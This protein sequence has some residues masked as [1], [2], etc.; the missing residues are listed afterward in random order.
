MAAPDLRHVAAAAAVAGT[1]IRYSFYAAGVFVFLTVGL[2][3]VWVWTRLPPAERDARGGPAF[4]LTSGDISRRPLVAHAAEQGGTWIETLQFGRLHDRDIDMTLMLVAP[5]ARHREIAPRH[6]A[7][8][9]ADLRPIAG[10]QRSAADPFYDLETR[11]GPVT[12][13]SFR[14]D[15]DGR[16][17]LCV[18]FLSRFDTPAFLYK[19]W[20]CEANGARPNFHTLACALDQLRMA[21]RLPSADAAAFLD[22]RMKRPA[23]C[24]AEPVSQTT[25]SG[26]RQPLR[27]LLR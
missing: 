14:I 22:E 5:A 24:S 1:A 9:I 3:A 19:G 20:Y 10:R 13:A 4:T 16:T 27:R 12:A 18:S 8:E 7:R 21:R 11:F 26:A 25:D 6:F 17:K 23:R 2:V 15:A